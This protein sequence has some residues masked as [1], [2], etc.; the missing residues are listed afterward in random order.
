M[1]AHQR[2]FPVGQ[3]KFGRLRV[4]SEICPR[5]HHR[6][7]VLCVCDCGTVKYFERLKVLVGHTTSC[8]CHGG[9]ILKHGHAR[10]KGR[11][12][13]EHLVWSAMWQRCANQNNPAWKR[14][15]AR[16]I[17]VCERWKEFMNFLADMGPRPAGR[18]GRVAAYS[19]ERINNNGNY[20]PG[21]CKWATVQE[22][23]ANTRY[24]GRK[25]SPASP[26]IPA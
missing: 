24:L 19:L 9:R 20:E 22:Q 4:V 11:R 5:R 6:P 10:K 1:P 12:S 13:P 15:G 25:R 18:N 16:G 7:Q 14:Y 8:G 17:A 2:S 3:T 23:R 21:N 26:S